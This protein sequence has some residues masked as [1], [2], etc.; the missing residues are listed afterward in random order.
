MLCRLYTV[1]YTIRLARD[2]GPAYWVAHPTWVHLV[3]PE[4]TGFLQDTIFAWCE[5]CWL[6]NH[7]ASRVLVRH[8]MVCMI[9]L[10]AVA[11]YTVPDTV[12]S[13][14][15]VLHLSKRWPCKAAPCCRRCFFTRSARACSSSGHGS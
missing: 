4:G 3:E 14:S 11:S 13:C 1:Q 9:Y 7:M 5:H 2:V 15:T 10:S 12:T 8:M 6:H